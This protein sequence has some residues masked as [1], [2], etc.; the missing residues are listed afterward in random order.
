MKLKTIIAPIFIIYCFIVSAQPQPPAMGWASW[1]HFHM[2][3]SEK[4]IKE[5]ADAMVSSGLKNVGYHFINIDDG[6]FNGRYANGMLRI[7]SLKFPN[8]MKAVADYIHSKELKAG[9]YTEAGSNTCGSMYDVTLGGVGGGLYGHEQKDIN[10]FFEDWD[11]DY[12]KVDYCGAQDQRLDE[13]T[14]YTSIRNAMDKTDKKNIN[15]N[16]CRWEFPGTWVTKVAD[17]WRIFVDIKPEWR[18]VC[19]IIDANTYLAPYASPGHY[20]DMDM[21]EVGRGLKPEEDK[22]HFSMWCVL[23]SPLILG[24]DLTDISASTMEIISNK[25]LI[26]INQDITGEI[27]GRL[28]S[29]K[30]KDLQVW[31]KRINGKQSN[32]RAVVLLNRTS[33]PAMMDVSLNEIDLTGPAK[34]H[35]LWTLTNDGQ[36]DSVFACEVPAHGVKVIKVTGAANKLQEN[37]E[38]EYAWIN[39]FNHIKFGQVI[40][41]QG[42]IVKGKECSGGAKASWLGNNKDNFIEFSKIMANKSGNYKLT[43]NYICSNQRNVTLTINGKKKFKLTGLSSFDW[44]KSSTISLKVPLKKGENIIRLSN[45]GNW[46]PDIDKIHINLNE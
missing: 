20:N 15:L 3:I 4:I 39:N 34:A 32:E 44:K 11:F 13:E 36:I 2:D 9:F 38:A 30:T 16:A 45:T 8:G 1:N 6:F 33:K 42:K 40:P 27:Q 43:L 21:L 28:I 31:A 37:F 12:L 29:E 46:M 26:A 5:Q 18:R 41:G 23:G 22:S 24:N 25:E 19:E 17:S 35:D 7:D 14:R 10:L